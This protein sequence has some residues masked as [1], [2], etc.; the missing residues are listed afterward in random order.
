MAGVRVTYS[1]MIRESLGADVNLSSPSP[2]QTIITG[3]NDPITIPAQSR[4][5]TI[6]EIHNNSGE[7]ILLDSDINLQ[8]A[9]TDQLRID[10]TQHAFLRFDK[11]VLSQEEANMGD[12]IVL[13]SYQIAD[14]LVGNIKE[15]LDKTTDDDVYTFVL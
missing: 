15:Q 11:S 4:S 14:Q 13:K 1:R 8:G 7:F 5:G 9:A 2:Y 6:I 12:R 10:N 3:Y